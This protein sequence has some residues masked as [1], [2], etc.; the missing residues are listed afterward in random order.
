MIP[1]QW[2]GMGW[3]RNRRRRRSRENPNN[4]RQPYRENHDLHHAVSG[5]GRAM[6]PE[7]S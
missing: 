2:L 7:R 4:I 5:S 3:A 6:P 1:R